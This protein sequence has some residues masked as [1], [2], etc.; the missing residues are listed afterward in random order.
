MH[1]D[2]NTICSI[3]PSADGAN[4]I[5]VEQIISHSISLSDINNFK[6][7]EFFIYA[8]KTVYYCFIISLSCRLRDTFREAGCGLRSCLRRAERCEPIDLL[9]NRY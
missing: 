2:K 8:L 1:R 4:P 7:L 3:N 9:R 5:S 6:S